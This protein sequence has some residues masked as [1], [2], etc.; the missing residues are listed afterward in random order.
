[1]DLGEAVELARVLGRLPGELVLY[2]VE[3]DRV[4]YGE[5]LS[6]QVAAAADRLAED[7]AAEVAAR[8]PLAVS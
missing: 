1:M 3:V 7:I 8:Q 4:G 5:G 6:P 2:A